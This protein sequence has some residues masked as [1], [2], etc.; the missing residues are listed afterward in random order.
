MSRENGTSYDWETKM[1]FYLF[2][3]KAY[4]TWRN[5][6]ENVA[7]KGGDLWTRSWVTTRVW[8][9]SDNLEIQMEAQIKMK[10]GTL[11]NEIDIEAQIK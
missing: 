5:Q 3:K 9:S 8:F 10:I 7:V 6:G 2:I 4:G 1:F 11:I